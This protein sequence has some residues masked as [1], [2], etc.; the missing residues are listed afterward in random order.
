MFYLVYA[1]SKFI[2]KVKGIEMDLQEKF[3]LDC[4]N[5]S[6]KYMEG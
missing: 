2:V 3:L 1:F 5:S 6:S 4:A